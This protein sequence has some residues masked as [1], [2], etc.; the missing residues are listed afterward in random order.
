MFDVSDPPPGER[1]MLATLDRLTEG[2]ALVPEV[3]S[4]WRALRSLQT[5]GLAVTTED[6]VD[7][8]FWLSTLG[9]AAAEAQTGVDPGV[10]TRGVA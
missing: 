6:A 2:Q 7:D 4:D 10:E 1:R 5:L 9:R 3:E 8:G